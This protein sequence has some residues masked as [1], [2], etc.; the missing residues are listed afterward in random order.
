MNLHISK[1]SLAREDIIA[2]LDVDS[3]TVKR[4]SRELLKSLERA[5][6]LKD[7]CDGELPRSLVITASADGGED[8]YY[9]VSPNT[10]TLEKRLG[11]IY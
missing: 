1:A 7:C 11:G 6:R 3:L 9:L 5:G 8:G 2:L 4:A 10:S